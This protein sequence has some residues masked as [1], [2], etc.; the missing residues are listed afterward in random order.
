MKTSILNMPFHAALEI[1]K[2]WVLEEHDGKLI[3]D[4]PLQCPVQKW[5]E[6]NDKGCGKD[7]VPNTMVC[8]VCGEPCCPVCFNH[9]AVQ[10]S[11]VTGYLSDVSAWNAS[12]KQEFEDRQ[13][14]DAATFA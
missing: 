10:I 14:T 3:L 5:I 13:I 8:P 12:K 1:M 6:Y 2:E 7:T 4:D 11:R 9:N